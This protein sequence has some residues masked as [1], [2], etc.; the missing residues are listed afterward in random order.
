MLETLILE[1]KNVIATRSIIWLHGL[2]A[3]A[4]DFVPVVP[5]LQ[6]QED[7]QVRFIFPTAPKRPVTI[8]NHYIMTA[9]YDIYSFDRNSQEDSKGIAASQQVIN[10]L[11]QEEYNKGV[12]Y[13][14]IVLAGFSQGGVIALYTALKFEHQ[15]AGVVGL[16]CYLPRV[17]HDYHPVNK[18][19]NIFL[20]HGYDDSI[21]DYSYGQRSH[22]LLADLGYRC[23]LHRYRMGHSVCA[24]EVSDIANFLKD[25]FKS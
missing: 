14:N 19:L 11:I 10:N 20:A 2:G 12:P 6:I 22:Q 5:E 21:V 13:E 4:Y 17:D 7:Y 24:E 1:P 25:I 16:S 18:N 23:K 15:L 3:D 9:W 8:N